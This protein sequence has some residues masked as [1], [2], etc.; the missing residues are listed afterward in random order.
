[1]PRGGR[2][3]GAGAPK[4]NT[5]ALKHGR[6]S[7]LYA[8]LIELLAQDPEALKIMREIADIQDRRKQRNLR[9][10]QRLLNAVVARTHARAQQQLLDRQAADYEARRAIPGGLKRTEDLFFD[11]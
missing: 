2:R 3:P 4:G 10:A 8:R 6:S 9:E 1:M 5:N 7:N 11:E